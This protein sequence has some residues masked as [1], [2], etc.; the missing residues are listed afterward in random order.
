MC[1]LS[2]V[3]KGL[4]IQKAHLL[5]WCSYLDLTNNISLL[6][7][8]LIAFGRCI[9]ENMYSCH[10]YLTQR[11]SFT[12]RNGLHSW[13]GRLMNDFRTSRRFYI[14]GNVLKPVRNVVFLVMPQ[15][16]S[17]R[18]RNLPSYIL[19]ASRLFDSCSTYN[20]IHRPKEARGSGN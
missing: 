1:F 19:M 20:S 10:D 5:A 14:T 4:K 18:M 15:I 16:T 8:E 9:E 3:L 7:F 17:L 6:M 2:S 11:N 12:C 13:R